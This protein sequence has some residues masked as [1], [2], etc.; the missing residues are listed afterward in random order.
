MSFSYWERTT[1]LSGIDVAVIGSGLVGL[2]AAITLREREPHLR[3][4]IFE[5]GML[6]SGA[7]TKNAGFACFC[8][9]SELLMDTE[10]QGEAA[11]LALVERRYRGLCRL[12]DRVGDCTLRYEALGGYEL[13]DDE[14]F[15][16]RCAEQIPSL[17]RQLSAIV[18]QAVYRCADERIADF[19]LGRTRRLIHNAYEG[20][21]HTGRMMAALLD[22]ARALGIV[23]YN[24]ATID[25]LRPDE[26]GVELV[27]KEGV[28]RVGKALV[29]TNA[30]A[31]Q[32][33]P[34]LDVT[35]GR[36]QVL[37]TA[38]VPGLC[39]RGAFHYDRGYVYFRDI[40]GRILLGGGRNLDY[41][42]EA[43]TEFGLTDT[44][45]QYLE[46]LLRTV[47]LPNQPIAIEHR[48][49][50]I[51]GFGQQQAP[52]VRKVAPNLVCAVKMQGMGVALGSLTGEEGA[53]MLITE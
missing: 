35:P 52:I 48:W 7:S 37:V 49:S 30:F 12:R 10:A 15:Y 13:F 50:G 17:N 31:R 21:L 28:V 47:V 20:Q 2:S 29:A 46:T 51:M 40:D 3:V 44:I 27:L 32:L 34:E 43:T 53:E 5:R 11:V 4:A 26:S 25:Q 9:V 42:V 16:Q 19:G 38:P 8:S 36:G 24:G 14:A 22:W 6:P 1:F 39:L 18:G 45:Q 41:A 23:I 33:L